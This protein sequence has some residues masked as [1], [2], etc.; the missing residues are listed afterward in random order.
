MPKYFTI[1][2][3]Q[4]TFS[5]K[6]LLF[7]VK[8]ISSSHKNIA[9]SKL[10]LWCSGYHYCTTSF[11][12]AGTQVL[13]RLKSCLWCVRDSRWWGSLTMFLAG[14]KAKCLLLINHTT[15][16]IHHLIIIKSKCKIS[17]IVCQ[18][19]DALFISRL[20]NIFFVILPEMKCVFQ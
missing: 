17:L 20:W 16:T 2:P 5:K 14:N 10:V 11:N 15:K 7:V 9:N 4:I 6:Y 8:M 19:I 1:M 12:K 13:S 18:L 3:K